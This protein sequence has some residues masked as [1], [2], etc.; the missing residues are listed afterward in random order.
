[1]VHLFN[2]TVFQILFWANT[3][4][5][6][7]T[8]RLYGPIIWV[9]RETPR[10]TET[11]FLGSKSG[12]APVPVPPNTDVHLNMYARQVSTEIW[13][14]GALH[15]RPDR[16][17][18]P[19]EEPVPAG[20]IEHGVASERK[21][22]LASPPSSHFSPWILGP[23]ICP[24]MKFSQVS[25]PRRRYTR[26]ADKSQV[27][28]VAAISTLFSQARVYPADSGTKGSLKPEQPDDDAYRTLQK[29]VEDS[30]F[31]ESTLAITRPEDV[32]LVWEMRK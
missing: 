10:N 18:F 15:F 19:E 4:Q 5:Q 12:K 2:I 28:F 20:W 21:E 26:Q 8:L 3:C 6:Y 1:M 16:F 22:K 23:R 11:I 24:G 30:S 7:E 27:E 29:T 32:R 13:G 9:P 25:S 17:V 31:R 14:P